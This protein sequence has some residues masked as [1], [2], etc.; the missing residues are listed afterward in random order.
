LNYE[1]GAAWNKQALRVR[2][3]MKMRG[4]LSSAAA[5]TIHT[6]ANVVTANSTRAS[7][8]AQVVPGGYQVGRWSMVSGCELAAW[9]VLLCVIHD[10]V[11]FVRDACG[12]P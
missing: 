1:Q 2:Y 12:S 9:M 7:G 6:D 4:D 3:L 11:D 10:A 5:R 8:T